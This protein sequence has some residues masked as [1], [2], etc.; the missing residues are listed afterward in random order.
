VLYTFC[1][2]SCDRYLY[3]GVIFDGSG[4]L[5]GTT[6]YSVFQLSPGTNGWTETTLHSFDGGSDGEGLYSGVVFGPDGSLYGTT[7]G[8]GTGGYGT[9]YSVTP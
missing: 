5:Y 7:E 3:A 1:R 9:A 4:N 2:Q 8:G 6:A